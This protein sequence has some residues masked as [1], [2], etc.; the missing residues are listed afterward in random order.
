M[1]REID[2][3][4]KQDNS[5]YKS[6]IE[7]NS[8]IN[9]PY[10]AIRIENYPEV[11]FDFLQKQLFKNPFLYYLSDND[12][13][14]QYLD[15][16]CIKY[17]S[18]IYSIGGLCVN[19]TFKSQTKKKVFNQYFNNWKK[20]YEIELFDSL[21][22]LDNISNL[23]DSFYVKHFKFITIG[24]TFLLTLIICLICKP[25]ESFQQVKFIGSFLDKFHTMVNQSKLLKVM[26]EL[27]CVSSLFLCFI[28]VFYEVTSRILYRKYSHAFSRIEKLIKRIKRKTSKLFKRI[29]KHYHKQFKSKKLVNYPMEK[30]YKKDFYLKNLDDLNKN[31]I[32]K[33]AKLKK[34]IKR[35]RKWCYFTYILTILI[36]IA[37]IALLI[38]Q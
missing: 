28:V 1:N 8:F 24:F 16:F 20:Q 14:I 21:N 3:T 4:K 15:D 37:F 29:K 19:P 33:L 9:D 36:N 10:L 23:S 18:R 11:S 35:T 32:N 31:S 22:R 34:K 6:D 26:M 38:I 7:L 27:S 30:I 17:N 5:S 12:L 25:T 13:K 2:L